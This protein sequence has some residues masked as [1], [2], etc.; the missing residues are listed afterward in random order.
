MNL[1]TNSLRRPVSL[2][3]FSP[4]LFSLLSFSLPFFSSAFS[5]PLLCSL[6]IGVQGGLT[7]GIMLVPQGKQSQKGDR[8]AGI[9]RKFVDS[10]INLRCPSSLSL[11]IP[12]SSLQVWPT[13]PCQTYRRFTDSMLPLLPGETPRASFRGWRESRRRGDMEGL[14]GVRR[15]VSVL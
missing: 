12:A 8:R 7:V 6:L 2:D 3:R 4:V 11:H 10:T 1:V 14:G 5:S 15:P 9:F 13:L